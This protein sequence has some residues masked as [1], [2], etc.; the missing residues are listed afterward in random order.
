MR[1]EKSTKI[2]LLS[3]LGRYPGSASQANKNARV[4]RAKVAP[5]ETTSHNSDITKRKCQLF[6]MRMVY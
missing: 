2:A 4:A 1:L 3:F 5:K 6:R